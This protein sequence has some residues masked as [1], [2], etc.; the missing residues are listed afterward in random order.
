MPGVDPSIILSANQPQFQSPID[1]ANKALTMRALLSQGQAE[2]IKARQMQQE[3]DDNQAIRNA[4]NKHTMV[5]ANGMPSIDQEGVLKELGESNNPS[6][7]PKAAMQFSQMNQQIQQQKLATLHANITA[8][9]EILNGVHDQPSYEKAL[10]Q[11]D[12][13]GLNKD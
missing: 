8:G 11:M 10:Q 2:D 9:S 3:F 5:D 13:L 6:L 12:A 1:M 7:A 4:T